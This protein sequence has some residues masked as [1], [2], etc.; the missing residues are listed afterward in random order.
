MTNT[1]GSAG[2]NP[3]ISLAAERKRRGLEN[4][5]ELTEEERTTV[6]EIADEVLS[7]F[8]TPEDLA[9]EYQRLT[10]RPN[11]QSGDLSIAD[12]TVL[13][14]ARLENERATAH[15][16]MLT[17]IKGI[18]MDYQNAEDKTEFSGLMLRAVAEQAKLLLRP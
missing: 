18:F 5:V 10:R 4:P 8:S 11:D 2:E 16:Y 1:P 7:E 12:A 13:A 17:T 3:P 9:K 14:M 6:G 15:N